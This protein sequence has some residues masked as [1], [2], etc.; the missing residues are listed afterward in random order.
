MNKEQLAVVSQHSL[1]SKPL[2]HCESDALLCFVLKEIDH[3]YVTV[4]IKD[5]TAP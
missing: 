1:N 2:L 4:Q 3:W 5:T